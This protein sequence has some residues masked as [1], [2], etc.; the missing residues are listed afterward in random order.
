MLKLK[1]ALPVPPAASLVAKMLM[2]TLFVVIVMGSMT[3]AA[4]HGHLHL[5]A[6]RMLSLS[7][8]NIVGA[9]PSRPHDLTFHGGTSK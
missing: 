8:V 7:L 1:R 6:L 2:S 3:A 9:L 4:P 5:N